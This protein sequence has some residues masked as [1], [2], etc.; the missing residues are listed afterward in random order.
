MTIYND[1]A[2]SFL[3]ERQMMIPEADGQKWAETANIKTRDRQRRALPG[4]AKQPLVLTAK[5][6]DQITQGPSPDLLNDRTHQRPGELW[7]D[8]A[9]FSPSGE[10]KRSEG[11]PRPATRQNPPTSPGMRQNETK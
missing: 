8:R 4:V 3:G 2:P 6:R 5:P 10:A 11:E 7:S 1:L 9:T